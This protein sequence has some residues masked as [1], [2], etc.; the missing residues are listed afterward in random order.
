VIKLSMDALAKA[1]AEESLT[2]EIPDP[3][4]IDLSPADIAS[5]VARSSNAFGRAARLAGMARAEAKRAKGRYEQKLRVS[6]QEG[7]NDYERAANAAEVTAD[8]LETWLDAE[9][10]ATVAESVEDAA[11][12]ASESARKLLDKIESLGWAAAREQRGAYQ[13]KDFQPY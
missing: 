6:R 1:I 8:E 9:E 3:L 12:V 4:V 7:K 11:R 13:E 10:I 2:V 5:L